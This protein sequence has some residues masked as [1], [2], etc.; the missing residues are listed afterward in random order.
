MIKFIDIHETHPDF[1]GVE[2]SYANYAMYTDVQP[3]E[4]VRVVSDKCLEVRHM[5][6]KQLHTP[7]D[8]GWIS[9]GFAGHATK[10]REGQKWE[11]TS[12]L[13]NRVFKI[14]RQKNGTWKKAGGGR[15]YLSTEPHKFHDY[16][17]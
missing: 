15:F 12:N 5:D 17:F 11:I 13:N 1:K 6:A 10:N 2:F 14:R 9:G 4:I 16:N 8:L 3:Y 7:E